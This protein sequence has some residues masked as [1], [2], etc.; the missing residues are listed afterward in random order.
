MTRARS[1]TTAMS[2]HGETR[3]GSKTAHKLRCGRAAAL[4]VVLLLALY[5]I[6]ASTK[7]AYHVP[8][9]AE[10]RTEPSPETKAVARLA[11]AAV[12]TSV[13]PVLRSLDAAEV[14]AL[15][16]R[17]AKWLRL[18]SAGVV[19]AAAR[20]LAA[21][22]PEEVCQ[23]TQRTA[24]YA[25]QFPSDISHLIPLIGG[26]MRDGQTRTFVELGSRFGMSTSILLDA[27]QRPHVGSIR[28]LL[29][30]RSPA[31]YAALDNEHGQRDKRLV[32]GDITITTSVLAL[33]MASALCK[34]MH[35]AAAGIT[36][37]PSFSHGILEGDD[38]K[39]VIPF[40][41]YDLDARVGEVAVGQHLRDVQVSSLIEDDDVRLARAAGDATAVAEIRRSIAQRRRIDVAFLDTVHNGDQVYMELRRFAP[42]VAHQILFHDPL[43][44]AAHD[45][46]SHISASLYNASSMGPRPVGIHAAIKRFLDEGGDKVWEEEVLYPHNN[47]LYVLRRRSYTHPHPAPVL[48][49]VAAGAHAGVTFSS[50]DLEDGWV[51]KDPGASAL[52]NERCT[53][54]QGYMKRIKWP[55]AAD[56]LYGNCS[57]VDDPTLYDPL[58]ASLM[59]QDFPLAPIIPFLWGFTLSHVYG[60]KGLH[61]PVREAFAAHVEI[62]SDPQVPA[63]LCMGCHTTVRM[64]LSKKAYVSFDD[65]A[66][67]GK[68]SGKPVGTLVTSV[69]WLRDQGGDALLRWHVGQAGAEPDARAPGRIVVYGTAM[70]DASASGSTADTIWRVLEAN[71]YKQRS[72]LTLG[73][74]L[75]FWEKST[76]RQQRYMKELA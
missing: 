64:L 30:T 47:G 21:M 60:K 6:V 76:Y 51:E 31:A 22:A 48:S 52:A 54:M 7:V 75:S 20:D 55:I 4:V 53:E 29:A 66:W 63:F 19:Q 46:A 27:L 18:R 26:Y 11:S 32:T 74:G 41:D 9:P 24:A 50:A 25:M 8:P 34:A 69:F 68:R 28:R 40:I 3:R 10:Q 42:Y 13:R 5:W 16:P 56:V 62:A 72:Q 73:A 70:A 15:Q 71:G 67:T 59:V 57:I 49:T 37:P 39:T 1:V 35:G 33:H 12:L 44:F 58:Y 17:L 65:V 38:L 45:E 2:A 23:L 14:D 61:F 36:A 43:S